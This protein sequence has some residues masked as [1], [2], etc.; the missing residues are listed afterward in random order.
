[1][2]ALCINNKYPPNT[3]PRT[4][5]RRREQAT[6][7]SINQTRK[8]IKLICSIPAV[9]I[10]NLGRIQTGAAHGLLVCMRSGRTHPRCWR[11]P[12]PARAAPPPHRCEL[13]GAARS[14][15]PPPASPSRAHGVLLLPPLLSPSLVDTDLG[16]P[17]LVILE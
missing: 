6:P 16:T 4:E 1:M 5:A 9:Q 12:V 7:T 17:G 15:A 3:S 10:S 11:R 2:Y 14:A 13:H 8:R